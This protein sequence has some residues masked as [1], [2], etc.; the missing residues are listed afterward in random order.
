MK[1]RKA[2]LLGKKFLIKSNLE[3]H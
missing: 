3:L 2:P 1:P